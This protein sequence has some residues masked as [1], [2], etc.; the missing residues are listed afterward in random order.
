MA[1]TCTL[2]K[3]HDIIQVTMGWE[4]IHLYQFCVRSACYGSWELPASSPNVTLAALKLRE[5]ARLAYEYD[6]NIP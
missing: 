4:G 1:S 3:L 2:H 6:L 5:G